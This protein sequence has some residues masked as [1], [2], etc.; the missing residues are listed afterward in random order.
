MSQSAIKKRQKRCRE[1]VVDNLLSQHNCITTAMEPAHFF[2]PAI[3]TYVRVETGRLSESTRQALELFKK[4][5]CRN[6][7]SVVV[8]IFKKYSRKPIVEEIE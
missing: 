4:R 1:K 3:A 5:R 7:E 8:H 2:V 6:G